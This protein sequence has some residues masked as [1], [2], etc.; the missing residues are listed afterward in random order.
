MG[1]KEEG[2][3]AAAAAVVVA[4]V[5][6]VEAEEEEKARPKRYKMKGGYSNK[7]VSQY[8]QGWTGWTA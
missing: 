5:V 3:A 7:H 4:A 2:E 1:V 8:I 6:G